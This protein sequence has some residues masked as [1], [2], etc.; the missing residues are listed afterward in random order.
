MIFDFTSG[1]D[2]FFHLKKK[3]NFSEKTV[4]FYGAQILLGLEYLHKNKI[5]YRDLKPEN[6]LLDSA[7]NVKLCDFGVS[8][9]LSTEDK[10]MSL[11]GTAQY[12]APEQVFMKEGYDFSVDIWSFGCCLYELVE[13]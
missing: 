2:L 6:I 1:G 8:K 12:M 10:T 11:I 9:S 3:G 7:G 4:Q 13:G 5:L